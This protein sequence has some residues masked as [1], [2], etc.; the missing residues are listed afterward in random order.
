MS[1]EPTALFGKN[2]TREL[3]VIVIDRVT[4]TPDSWSS[5]I[6]THGLPTPNRVLYQTEPC[7]NV[8]RL[9]GAGNAVTLPKMRT[10]DDGGVRNR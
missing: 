8:T 5:E 6:R 1:G 2:G 7:P 10:H 3:I 9:C 4:I